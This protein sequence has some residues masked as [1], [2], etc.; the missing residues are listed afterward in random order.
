MPA[1]IVG[2]A[3]PVSFVCWTPSILLRLRL[4]AVKNR[5]PYRGQA[6]PRS[7]FLGGGISL[8]AGLFPRGAPRG[9][10]QAQAG[11]SHP[12]EPREPAG[13]GT[14]QPEAAVKKCFLVAL[15]IPGAPLPAAVSARDGFV[16]RNRTE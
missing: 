5:M 15:V 14:V 8:A 11:P 12:S 6:R 4:S 16:A 2:L 10:T 1:P 9:H 3:I 7:A 13:S